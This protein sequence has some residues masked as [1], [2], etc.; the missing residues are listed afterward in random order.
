MSS[1]P[2]YQHHR[3]IITMQPT[4]PLPCHHHVLTTSTSATTSGAT[5]P[6]TRITSTQSTSPASLPP[7][8]MSRQSSKP[9]AFPPPLCG[10][11][12]RAI[13]GTSDSHP[14]Y[15]IDSSRHSCRFDYLFHSYQP[16]NL[17]ACIHRWLEKLGLA[18]SLGLRVVMRQILY[19]H[20]YAL[21]DQN[22][23]PNPVNTFFIYYYTNKNATVMLRLVDKH[24]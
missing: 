9:Q 11:V 15:L 10:S 6:L 20:Y 19:S 8:P 17:H 3:A 13:H 7:L 23:D 2:R 5:Q 12:K 16:H 4:T 18:A 21:L 1:P 24:W 14:T 22:L